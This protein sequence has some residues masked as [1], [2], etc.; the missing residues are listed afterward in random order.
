MERQRTRRAAPKEIAVDLD[1][2]LVGSMFATLYDQSLEPDVRRAKVE[3]LADADTISEAARLEIIAARLPRPDWP[4]S[5][6]HHIVLTAVDASSGEF[7]TFDHSSGVALLDAVAASC[8]VPG[9]WPPVS[10]GG[11]RYM[12]GGTRSIAN[13]DLAEGHD[14]IVILT[15]Q[16]STLVAASPPTRPTAKSVTVVGAPPSRWR[17]WGPILSILRIV[18]LR[19]T[20]ATARVSPP[21][22]AGRRLELETRDQVSDDRGGGR[23]WCR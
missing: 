11:R 4:R 20:K 10:I 3:A 14:D 22:P 13:A 12:D 6:E 2:E 9:I 23:G 19:S 5:E 21:P 8:A 16:F 15:R 7:T 17:R 18:P 1:L